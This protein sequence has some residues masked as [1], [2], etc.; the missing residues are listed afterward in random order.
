MHKPL[1]SLSKLFISDITLRIFILLTV[2]GKWRYVCDDKF[3]LSD[4]EVVCRE[5]GFKLGASE[6]RG[7][8]YYPPTTGD[9]SFAMD[10]VECRGDETS[11]KECNFKGWGVSNCG[12]DEVVGVV[13]KVPQLKCPNNYWLCSTSQ[14]CIP[15]AFVCDNTPDCAD[16][17]DESEN[18]CNVRNQQKLRFIKASVFKC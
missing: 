16:K 13:C 15:P 7:F 12:P 18:V 6:V 11:L 14:E 2:L 4:A 1:S 10:E 8:S 3:G 17:S 5:L 9:V